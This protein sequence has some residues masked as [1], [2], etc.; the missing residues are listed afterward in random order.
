MTET[1]KTT[2]ETGT[3]YRGMMFDRSTADAE[4]RTIEVSFSSEEPYQRY[5]GQEILDHSAGSVRLERLNSGGAFLKDHNWDEQ[6]G[7]IEK[8]FIGSDRRG[9]AVVRFSRSGK[10]EEIFQDIL[11]GIRVGISVGYIVHQMK[12]ES[13]GDDGD[14]YRVVDWEPLEISTVSVPADITV[15][16]GRSTEE[17]FKTIIERKVAMESETKTTEKVEPKIDV[18]SI[19]TSATKAERERIREILAIGDQHNMRELAQKAVDSGAEVSEFRAQVLEGLGRAAKVN[20]TAEIGMS[21][22][23]KKQYSL[24]RAI[25]AMASGKRSE[26]QFEFDCSDAVGKKLGKQARGLYIPMDMLLSRS[27]NVGTPAEGGY[28]KGTDH[29]GGSFI[30]ALRSRSV[31]QQMGAVMM[32]GLVGDIA[33]PRLDGGSTAY[34]VDEAGDITGTTPAFGSVAMSPKTVGAYID[35]TRKLLLQ[36]SPSVDEL[37]KSDMSKVLAAAIDAAGISGAS[38]NKQPVGILNTSGIGAVV[39]GDNGVAP[40][41]DH[42]IKLEQE[43]AVDNADLGNLA[44]LTNAKVRGKLKSTFKNATYGDNPIWGKGSGPGIGELNGYNA[45]TTSHVP[46]NLT[47]GSSNGVASAIIFGNFADLIIALWGALDINLDT[48]TLS[49]SGGLRLVMLQDC[50]VAVRHAQSFAAMKD[51]LTA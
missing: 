10:A 11:D 6:V 25:A 5:F 22:S 29:L 42:I 12:L 28:L 24:S 8:A 16:V 4:N 45:F 3:F 44:Y 7:V 14:N 19:E 17:K 23:D 15:G 20:G 13:T 38:A 35:I 50:D 32:E 21:D 36:S 30:D 51:A 43:V 9:R 18:K 48:A 40:T 1:K 26:A 41:W 46:G 34:W 49:K 27:A 39:G 31:L 2:I 37:L 47:K 33:I